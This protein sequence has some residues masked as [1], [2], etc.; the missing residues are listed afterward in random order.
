MGD[1]DVGEWRNGTFIPYVFLMLETLI[2]LVPVAGISIA[3]ILILGRRLL[4]RP[5]F[6]KS[7]SPPN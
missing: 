2:W 5:R 7:A 4:K 1:Y 3:T 6:L